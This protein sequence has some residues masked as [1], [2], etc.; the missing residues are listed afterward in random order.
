MERKRTTQT[1][2]I[3]SPKAL[4]AA[5]H[6]ARRE[7]GLSQADLA[8]K[9]GTTRHRISRLERGDISDQLLLILRILERLQVELC[10]ERR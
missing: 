7:A 3:R 8:K 10:L 1:W 4:G 5:L 9:L 6:D 2:H